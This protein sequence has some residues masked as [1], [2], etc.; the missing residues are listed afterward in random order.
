MSEEFLALSQTN[1]WTLVPRPP[2]TNIV[3][4]KWIFKTKH[5][6]DGS[7]EK[8][9]ARLIALGFTQ[10]HGI[11]YDDT[12][13]LIVKPTTIRLVLSIAVSCGGRSVRLM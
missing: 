7:I 11:D 13:S 10:W 6:S 9:K 8:H 12:F 2:G 3:G 1:M 4:S 5:H